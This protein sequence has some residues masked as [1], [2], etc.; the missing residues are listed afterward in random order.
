MCRKA[1]T[2]AISGLAAYGVTINNNVLSQKVARALK[3]ESDNNGPPSRKKKKPSP[4]KALAGTDSPGA[5]TEVPVCI[6]IPIQGSLS[7]SST[8][9][10]SLEAEKP[11]HPPGRPK[12]STAESKRKEEAKHNMCMASITLEYSTKFTDVKLLGK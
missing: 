3:S 12:G 11:H 1:L 4:E 5:P 2:K 7:T 10:N 9:T 6:V 8:L